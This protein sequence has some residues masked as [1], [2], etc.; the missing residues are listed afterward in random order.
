MGAPWIPPTTIPSKSDGDPLT[1]KDL[2]DVIA[3]LQNFL[4]GGAVQGPATSIDGELA[5]FLG[6]TGSSTTGTGIIYANPNAVGSSSSG[7]QEAINAAAVIGATTV[8]VRGGTHF[9]TATITHPS[10]IHVRGQGMGVTTVKIA[11]GANVILWQ[12]S[13]TSG[14]NSFVSLSDMTFDGNYQNQTSN[15]NVL[16][17]MKRVT[18]L[19]IDR[20][21]FGNCRA[22]ALYIQ[23]GADVKRA[24]VNRSYFHNTQTNVTSVAHAALYVF[25]G[26]GGSTTQVH[27]S[28]NTFENIGTDNASTGVGLDAIVVGGA[29]TARTHI[30]DNV[31]TSIQASAIKITNS[32]QVKCNGNTITSAGLQNVADGGNGIFFDSTGTGRA[33]ICNNTVDTVPVNSDNGVEVSGLD[34]DVIMSGNRVR[35]ILNPNKNGMAVGGWNNVM[36][37]VNL[38]TDCA[39]VGFASLTDGPTSS[40]VLSVTGLVCVACGLGGVNIRGRQKFTL[41]G[42][43][44]VDSSSG[45]GI[46]IAEGIT[47]SGAE[48]TDGAINGCIGMGNATQGL[49]L[50]GEYVGAAGQRVRRISVNGGCYNANTLQGVKLENVVGVDFTGVTVDG[51]LDDG[52]LL[53]GVLCSDINFVGGSI[54]NH[55]VAGKFGINGTAATLTRISI[56]QSVKFLNNNTHTSADLGNPVLSG[57]TPSV[58]CVETA[59]VTN[60]GATTVTNLTGGRDGQ[61]VSL[62]HTDGN[63]TYQDG[64]NIFLAG[65]VNYNPTATSQLRL[66]RRNGLWYEEG[67]SVN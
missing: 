23:T 54:R 15:T 40:K 4:V 38:I 34:S 47:T 36:V 21:E 19:Q 17:H 48:P 52:V 30:I 49:I 10:Q 6:T 8:V 33:E 57:A 22:D 9:S 65:S 59:I 28:E 26:A 64:T 62:H 2:K 43:V 31:L 37:G 16:V 11:N 20:C 58:E 66:K 13:N 67:R 35:N 32:G 56:S 29:P 45:F 41:N 46:Q 60:G 3:S 42:V 12:N 61:I 27:I 24:W 39:G 53:A 44:C 51:N 50:A 63:T 5:V 14:G 55:S 7:I 1:A 25:N 18:N